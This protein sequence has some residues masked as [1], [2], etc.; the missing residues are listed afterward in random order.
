M[1]KSKNAE[2]VP[3]GSLIKAVCGLKKVTYVHAVNFTNMAY[4]LPWISN[5]LV[6]RE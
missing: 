4:P 5:P 1:V 3:R 6:V 2:G